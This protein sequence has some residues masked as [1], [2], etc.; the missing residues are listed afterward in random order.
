MVSVV[1]RSTARPLNCPV[2]RP[3]LVI[4]ATS[5][6][7]QPDLRDVVVSEAAAKAAS[8]AR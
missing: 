7:D 4:Q 1:N 8:D 3:S 2:V 6:S 5:S